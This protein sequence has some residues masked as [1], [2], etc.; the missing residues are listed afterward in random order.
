MHEYQA[1][2]QK[3]SF[4]EICHTP[5]LA[6]EVTLQPID[7][8]DMDAAIIFSD[9]LIPLQAMGLAL[10]VT[11]K[12]GPVF[13]NPLKAPAELARLRPFNPAQ[14]T[15][16]LLSA[17]STL[18]PLMHARNKALLGFAG[19]PWT[20]ATYALEGTSWKTGKATKQWL[21]GAPDAL[22]ALLALLSAQLIDYLCAQLEAGAD[23]VQL[24]DTWA[25]N[26]P[27]PYYEAFVF[28]YQQQ[29]IEGVKQRHPDAPVILF[30]KQS[31]GLWPWLAKTKADVVSVDE[32]TPLDEARQAMAQGGAP[33]AILQG[34][35][36]SSL[37]FLEDTACLKNH[38]TT[39]LQ[40]GG[41]QRYIANLGHGVLP[42]TP[43]DNVARFVDWVKASEKNH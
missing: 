31:R 6:V 25:A 9:I 27:S 4:L 14:Q 41:K 36:D 8:F 17:L 22:H 18:Q 35:L 28:N 15:P 19:C 32:W 7:A 16:F 26:I 42:Q 21:Y 20:L 40:Q 2:R 30:V 5:E 1:V 33:N 3:A 43:R 37:L 29:V 39:M 11:D 10:E 24:F 34:N 23:A 13:A 12:H 38:V